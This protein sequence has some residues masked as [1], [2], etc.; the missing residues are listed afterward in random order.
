MWDCYGQRGR[1]EDEVRTIGGGGDRGMIV[2]GPVGGGGR[3]GGWRG[4]SGWRGGGLGGGNVE[5]RG[6]FAHCLL[7]FLLVTSEGWLLGWSGPRVRFGGAVTK[8]VSGVALGEE[9]RTRMGSD[10]GVPSHVE[11]KGEGGA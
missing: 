2:A 4:R 8:V 9:E 5:E 6:D 3:R 1:G 7:V 10:R 11:G